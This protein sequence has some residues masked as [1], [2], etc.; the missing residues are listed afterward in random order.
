MNYMVL[1]DPSKVL[2]ALLI[3]KR[4]VDVSYKCPSCGKERAVTWLFPDADFDF[5]DKCCGTKVTLSPNKE[6][7]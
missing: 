2:A 5:T 4:A 3:N 6:V 7:S 1:H